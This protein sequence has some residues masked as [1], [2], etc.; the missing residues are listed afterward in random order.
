MFTHW[1]IAFKFIIWIIS[2]CNLI[3]DHSHVAECFFLLN[4]L[5]QNQTFFFRK[6][7]VICS[8]KLLIDTHFYHFR[9][10]WKYESFLSDQWEQDELVDIELATQLS[11]LDTNKTKEAVAGDQIILWFFFIESKYEKCKHR[12]T[13]EWF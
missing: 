9:L 13:W 12:S 4:F 6:W 10:D 11:F 5:F 3:Y 1:L 7:M 8:S 2:F